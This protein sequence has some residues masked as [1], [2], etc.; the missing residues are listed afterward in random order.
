MR[1]KLYR[2]PESI[3]WLGWIEDC[4]G[5]AIG[6]IRLDGRVEFEW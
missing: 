4:K 3:G 1:V 5:R 2:N 6:F